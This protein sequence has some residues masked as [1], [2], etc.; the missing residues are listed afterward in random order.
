MNTEIEVAL[1]ATQFAELLTNR[2]TCAPAQIWDKAAVR[3]GKQREIKSVQLRATN[4]EELATVLLAVSKADSGWIY[5]LEER[6]NHHRRGNG[7]DYQ[8]MAVRYV[9]VEETK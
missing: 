4:Q 7:D 5:D 3:W 9:P 1:T 2:P 8:V 6:F